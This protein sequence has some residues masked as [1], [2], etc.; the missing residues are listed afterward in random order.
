MPRRS[1]L[2]RQT[3]ANVIEIGR[4][5]TEAGEYICLVQVSV[6]EIGSMASA[7]E[8]SSSARLRSPLGPAL[9]PSATG[10]QNLRGSSN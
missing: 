8:T 9:R 7:C 3:V 6:Y 1:V 5:L 2:G 10:N 4:R